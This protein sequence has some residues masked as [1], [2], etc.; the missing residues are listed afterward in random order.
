M[1]TEKLVACPDPLWCV[2]SHEINRKRVYRQ[3][4]CQYVVSYTRIEHPWFPHVQFHLEVSC[5]VPVLCNNITA[6]Q[7]DINKSNLVS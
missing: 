5:N 3:V 7:L 2:M 6:T 4:S 1:N